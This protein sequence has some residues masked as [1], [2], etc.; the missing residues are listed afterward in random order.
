[1]QRYGIMRREKAALYDASNPESV[2]YVLTSMI[3]GT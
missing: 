1:M 2:R 3:P